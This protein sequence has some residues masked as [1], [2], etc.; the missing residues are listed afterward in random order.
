MGVARILSRVALVDFSK[1]FSR[2]DK[3]GGICFLQLKTKKTAF[4]A[5]I[6]KH[7]LLF[8]HPCLCVGKSA[9]HTIKNWCDFKRFNTI[10][11]SE[12]LLNLIRKMKCLTYQ[13]QLS[14]CIG[15]TNSCIYFCIGNKIGILTDNLLIAAYA[16][17]C[18]CLPVSNAVAECLFNHVTS[19]FKM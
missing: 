2:G 11:N 6:F 3:S 7:L 9:C 5:E 18:L 16:L 17:S 13:F 8:Q 1:V 19:V 10:P 4:F 15:N 12:I 14:F